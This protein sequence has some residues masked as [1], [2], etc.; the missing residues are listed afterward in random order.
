MNY[1][2]KTQK[3]F[4]TSVVRK[5]SIF[6]LRTPGDFWSPISARGRIFNPLLFSDEIV[7]YF[8]VIFSFENELYE[9]GA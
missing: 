8:N 5:L 1:L 9:I 2:S 7:E 6:K 4:Q 3:T